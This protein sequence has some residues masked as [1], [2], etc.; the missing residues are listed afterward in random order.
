MSSYNHLIRT[1][2]AGL[3]GRLKDGELAACINTV[4]NF[5]LAWLL[6]PLIATWSRSARS[7]G[8]LQIASSSDCAG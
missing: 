1:A 5:G 6:Y 2:H 3:G 4:V 7:F 8:V